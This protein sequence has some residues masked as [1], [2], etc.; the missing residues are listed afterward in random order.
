MNVSWSDPVLTIPLPTTQED[1]TGAQPGGPASGNP[2]PLCWNTM[3][4]LCDGSRIMVGSSVGAVC[5]IGLATSIT[6]CV[7]TARGRVPYYS[8]Y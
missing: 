4:W 8:T 7:R 5:G 3:Q 1:F 6:E 2:G